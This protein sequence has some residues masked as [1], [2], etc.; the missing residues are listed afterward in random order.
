[1][2]Y[3]VDDPT[4]RQTL[5]ERAVLR[6]MALLPIHGRIVLALCGGVTFAGCGGTDAPSEQL[7]IAVDH[8]VHLLSPRLVDDWKSVGVLFS[9]P[10]SAYVSSTAALPRPWTRA[11]L[12]SM[13]HVYG[14]P[15]VRAALNLDLVSERLRVRGENEH[16]GREAARDRE[17]LVGFCSVPLLRPYADEELAYCSGALGIPGIKIH[18]PAM[19]LSLSDPAHVQLLARVAERAERERIAI[20]I[21]ISPVDGELSLQELQTFIDDIIAPHPDLELYLAHLGGNGGY[22]V[23]AR[24]VVQGMSAFFRS[25]ENAGQRPVYLE[26]SGALLSRRSDGVPASRRSDATRLADDLRALGLER[27]L[28]GSD[29]PVFDAPEFATLLR[30][31]L[32]LTEAELALLMTN[33]SPRLRDP[34][35][36][37]T[38]P[39]P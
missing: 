18:L 39:L 27:V 15:E 8:H 34:R 31:R 5:T 16:I 33:L 13:A 11:F 29:Y 26:I 14:S 35:T 17:S 28:F 6:L 30:D 22:R 9:R 32:P 3:V 20:L 7:D 24:R 23:S 21:H 25:T 38:A 36:P 10:E 4:H 19:G 2:V 1:M 37:P 12:V